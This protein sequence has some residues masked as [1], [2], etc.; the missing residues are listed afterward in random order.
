MTC[1]MHSKKTLQGYMCIFSQDISAFYSILLKLQWK[2][3]EL[4]EHSYL[5]QMTW[6]ESGTIYYTLVG[7]AV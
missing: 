7:S 5:D 4:L 3:H 6:V 2:L 1:G